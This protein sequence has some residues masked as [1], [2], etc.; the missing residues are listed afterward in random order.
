MWEWDL[1]K[2][3]YFKYQTLEY[4]IEQGFGNKAC[5]H[6]VEKTIGKEC[7]ITM[8]LHNLPEECDLRCSHMFKA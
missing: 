4:S 8:E 3:C 7:S 2:T 1:Y 5:K 6:K